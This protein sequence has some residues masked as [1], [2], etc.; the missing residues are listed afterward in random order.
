LIIFL[1]TIIIAQGT[2]IPVKHLD[3]V[4]SLPNISAK[5][6]GDFAQNYSIP[7]SDSAHFT[8][9]TAA[10]AASSAAIGWVTLYLPKPSFLNT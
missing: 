8:D 9:I 7:A 2:K 5:P 6:R 1:E 4:L 10:I 3:L